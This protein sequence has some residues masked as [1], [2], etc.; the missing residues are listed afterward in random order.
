MKKRNRLK[1][2]G[3]RNLKRQFNNAR[4]KSRTIA[5]KT[6]EDKLLIFSDISLKNHLNNWN[7]FADWVHENYKMRSVGK[8]TPEHVEKYIKE[9]NGQG[10]SKKT[11][12]SR[13]GAINKTM[14]K[15]WSEKE[16]PILSKM[17]IEVISVKENSYK[18]FT[19]Q[20]WRDRNEKRYGNYKET[21]DTVSAFG[22]R[23]KELREL[24]QKSFLIDKNGKI[25]VQTI[26]KGGKYRIAECTKEKND[27]MVEL[28]KKNS[29]KIGDITSFK[30]DK[31]FLERA[32]KTDNLKLDLRGSKNERNSWHIF[33]SEYA[34][35]LLEEKIERYNNLLNENYKSKQGYSTINV[36]KQENELKEIYTQIGKYRGSALAFVEVSR[37]L[38]HNRLDIMLRY[39]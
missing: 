13:I 10:M 5:K 19:A 3:E 35:K 30:Q 17:N 39:I 29:Q 12:Q 4:G 16:K 9:L 8:I 11:L 18:Q 32:I 27:E 22:L 1:E 24:N 20:E 26:G 28:Y 14:G 34:Q 33:R 25:F 31:K 7:Q 23:K 15:R 37:N 21:F 2:E 6:G 36:L 38:G